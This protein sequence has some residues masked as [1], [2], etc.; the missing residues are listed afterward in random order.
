[1]MKKFTAYPVLILLLSLSVKAAGIEGVIS[2]TGGKRLSGV[3]VYSLGDEPRQSAS[4]PF[5]FTDNK[6]KFKLRE[7]GKVLFIKEQGFRPV[8]KVLGAKEKKLNIILLPL[9]P[10]YQDLPTCMPINIP[11]LVGGRLKVTPPLM[12]DVVASEGDDAQDAKIRYK[13]G[14]SENWMTLMWGVMATPG[15]P[16]EKWIL[17]SSSYTINV[18]KHGKWELTDISGRTKDGKLWRFIGEQKILLYY[19]NAS[20][21]ASA[22]FDKIIATSC[23]VQ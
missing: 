7:V 18:L 10:P 9:S 12:S 3:F 21:E 14:T 19:E 5:T 17:E 6:G 2:D 22:Y 1:M 13:E 11:A 16:P 20:S 15:F 23:M 8:V 4:Y